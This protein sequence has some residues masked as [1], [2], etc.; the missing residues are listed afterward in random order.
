MNI[1]LI[2]VLFA[3][4]VI[5]ACGSSGAGGANSPS[6]GNQTGTT[7]VDGGADSNKPGDN[8]SGNGM[9]GDNAE[10]PVPIQGA[11][12]FDKTAPDVDVAG[13]YA[14]MTSIDYDYG[15]IPV[16]SRIDANLA[17]TETFN[18]DVKGV[19]HYP[20]VTAETPAPA[21]GFPVIIFQHGRHST[22]S[23]TG[24]ADGAESSGTDCEA[25]GRVDIRSDKGYDYIAETMATHGYVVA[26]IDANDVNSQD[27]GGSNDAGI[28]ARAELILHTLDIIRDIAENPGSEFAIDANGTDFSALF[29]VTDLSRVG[30]MGHSRGGN[31]VAKAVT[32]NRA[33]DINLRDNSPGSFTREHAMTAVFSLAP[34][35]FDQESPT[36]TTWVTLSP[37]CDGDVANPHGIYMYDNLRYNPDDV[38]GPQ[39]MITSL[40]ANHNFYNSFWFGDDAEPPLGG[41]DPYCLEASPIDGRYDRVDQERHGEFLIGSF[42]RLFV[43]GESQFAG[44]WGGKENL[45]SSACP[46]G[47][48]TCDGRIHLSFQ[49]EGDDVILLDDTLDSDSLNE[50]NLGQD[51]SAGLTEIAFWCDPGFGLG[52]DSRDD[53]ATGNLDRCISPATLA[54]A[55]QISIGYIGAIAN[56]TFELSDTGLD[57]SDMDFFTLRMGVSVTQDNITGQDFT[58]VLTDAS[59]TTAEMIATDYSDAL[60]FPPGLTISARDT[61][62]KTI[63]NMVPFRLDSVEIVD[64][65]IDLSQLIQ[66]QVRFDRK[67]AGS[68]QFTDVMFQRI[69]YAVR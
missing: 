7:P 42:L 47:V 18:A 36:N 48:G 40:G 21:E 9:P 17:R 27:G 19:L 29:G 55:A 68:V 60:Y 23:T 24:D 11:A 8:G 43:G 25:N 34:T 64:S 56:F 15:F 35:D 2:S 20:I 50:N 66:A 39:F 57:V 5:S 38:T 59:G 67:L 45:P 65:G 51:N 49:Q 28:T 37:Y 44:Y 69:P 46:A 58:L 13:P 63:N 26:S 16:T 6:E 10:P 52:L 61:G 54:G 12:R 14:A 32:Y 30:T 22:C 33:F 53:A 1:K 62:G 41:I 3:A 31:A 4:V